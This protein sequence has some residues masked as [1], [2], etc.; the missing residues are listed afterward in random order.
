MARG[1]LASAGPVNTQHD[2]TNTQLGYQCAAYMMMGSGATIQHRCKA[3][4]CWILQLNLNPPGAAANGICCAACV[5]SLAM[6]TCL[7]CVLASV[8]VT[9][10]VTGL[11]ARGA[12]ATAALALAGCFQLAGGTAFAAA[13]PASVMACSRLWRPAA[14]GLGS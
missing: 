2:T 8:L 10:F 12:A 4:S 1:W 14:L 9:G 13:W 11:S 3:L 7:G 6:P 5:I